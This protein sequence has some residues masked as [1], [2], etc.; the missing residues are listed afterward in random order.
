MV[1]PILEDVLVFHDAKRS[2]EYDPNVRL[3][4]MDKYGIEKQVISL[5]A[6]WLYGLPPEKGSNICGLVNDHI[7]NVVHTNPNRFIGCGILDLRNIELALGEAERVIKKLNFKCL[8]VGTHQGNRGLDDEYFY[9][10][11]EFVVSEN[12]PVFLHPISFDGYDLVNEQNGLGT[13]QTFGWPFETS[14]ATW[15]MIVGGIFDKFSR[16][17]IVTHHLGGMLPHFFGRA[18]YRFEKISDKKALKNYSD[19]FKQIY[20]DTA[21]DGMSV[22]TLMEGYEVFGSKNMI[23]GSDWPFI[24]EVISYGENINAINALPIP[25]EEK[26]DILYNNAKQLLSI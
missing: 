10:F 14:W 6:A 17:K 4:I 16:L 11:Y 24:D 15:K 2:F 7:S 25:S 21:L 3:K 23:F 18:K 1:P 20:A 26:I 19:Y 12:I 9:P 13:M 5:S 8:I 22:M